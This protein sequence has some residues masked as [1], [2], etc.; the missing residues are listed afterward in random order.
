MK[1]ILKKVMTGLTLDSMVYLSS[2]FCKLNSS[3]RG[4]YFTTHWAA[5][6]N[7]ADEFLSFII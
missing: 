4:E 5:N 7:I 3:S 2:R 1:L 6:S